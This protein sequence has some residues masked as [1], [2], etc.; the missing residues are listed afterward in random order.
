M[1]SLVISGIA[2]AMAVCMSDKVSA[3][4]VQDIQVLV[5]RNEIART[6]LQK[7]TEDVCSK[8]D[9]TAFCKREFKLAQDVFDL[10]ESALM[11][12]AIAHEGER[13]VYW[14]KRAQKLYDQAWD[15][16]GY[17]LAENMLH[18]ETFAREAAKA[19]P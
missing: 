11:M 7:D 6:L 13:R 9:E 2:A 12:A 14:A 16:Y 3:F 8:V 15:A 18:D 4:E 10:V 1:K 5:L 17:A 19:P